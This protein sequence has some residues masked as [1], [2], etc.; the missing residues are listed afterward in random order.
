MLIERMEAGC[1]SVDEFESDRR[2]SPCGQALCRPRLRLSNRRLT[3]PSAYTLL[4]GSRRFPRLPNFGEALT[5][6]RPFFSALLSWQT[7]IDAGK[8]RTSDQGWLGTQLVCR[9]LAASREKPA[10]AYRGRRCVP[11]RS[12]TN[13]FQASTA[14]VAIWN[15][16]PSLFGPG[17]GCRGSPFGA[18]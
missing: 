8:A 12:S 17:V 6:L 15:S 2:P 13:R 7:S 1:P 16:K 11:S 10:A 4:T 9:R 14:R 3:D 5:A 18:T